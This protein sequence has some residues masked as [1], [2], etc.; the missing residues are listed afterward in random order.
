MKDPVE[1]QLPAPNRFLI[2]LCMEQSGDQIPSTLLGDL[3]PDLRY[4][5]AID[6]VMSGSCMID[7]VHS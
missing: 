2:I 1:V 7:I 5:P 4:G 6:S 3:F